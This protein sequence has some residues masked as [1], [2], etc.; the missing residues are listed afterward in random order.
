M[1]EMQGR[2]R[3][4][5]REI[6]AR[7]G[8]RGRALVLG[9]ALEEGRPRPLARLGK[10]RRDMGEIWARCRR[11]AGGVQEEGCVLSR[12]CAPPWRCR[13]RTSPISPLS[14]HYISTTSPLHLPCIAPARRA[15]AAAPA[16]TRARRDAPA[17][18]GRDVGEIHGRY[19]GDVGEMQ[20]RWMWEM[21]ARYGAC[22]H[23]ASSDARR[24]LRSGA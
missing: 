1:G 2:C 21:R 18:Y 17:R 4:D 12:G 8:R 9:C 11:D 14:L 20:A 24:S 10:C 13:P 15:G 7:F 22:V 3:R 19:T 16:S 6:S 5:L 23:R